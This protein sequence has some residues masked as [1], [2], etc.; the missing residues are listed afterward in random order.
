MPVVSKEEL[1]SISLALAGLSQ[2]VG[3]LTMP[4]IVVPP[5]TESG[6]GA[7]I[8]AGTGKLVIKT[9]EWEVTTDGKL[10]RNGQLRPESGQV[11]LGMRDKDTFVQGTSFGG[12]YRAAGVEGNWTATSQGSWTDLNGV[13]PRAPVI[14][15]S[16]GIPKPAA[17]V[18]YTTRTFGPDLILGKNWFK[19]NLYGGDGAGNKVSQDGKGLLCAGGENGFNA[20][21][22]SCV[23]TPNGWRGK[24][25]GGGGFFE[26]T[27][28]WT[29]DYN[30]WGMP[31]SSGW[32]SWWGNSIESTTGDPSAQWKGQAANFQQACEFDF[33]EFWA[34]N[35]WGGA[36][37]SW[38]GANG[39][40]VSQGSDNV[41]P[42]FDHAQPNQY[43]TLWVPATPT[44]RG[45]AKW[46]FNRVHIPALD[47][48]WSMLDVNKAPPPTDQSATDRNHQN[49][50]LGT[51]AGNP[52]RVIACE[53]FQASEAGNIIR[54]L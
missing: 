21:A 47:I 45:Y 11:N 9:V 24:A 19:F 13:N 17:D 52:M 38:Y 1:A 34:N 53:V 27:L 49:L 23:A 25:F 15:P 43:G 33:M 46:F 44:S 26:A 36:I 2:R 3:A 40:K 51:G 18:G 39:E 10:K 4:V 29:G 31:G 41:P 5:A 32:P 48:N 14:P 8:T 28:L 20:H 30:G 7:Q 35:R 12:F 16:S 50:L 54:P 6:D 22:A 42:G 37:H